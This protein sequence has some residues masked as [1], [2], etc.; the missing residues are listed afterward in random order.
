MDI[1][2]LNTKFEKAK[3]EEILAF[4]L[5][6]FRGRIALSS[7]LGAE[8]QVLTH[9]I[10]KI[11]PSARIFTLD[12]GRLFPETYD[13]IHKINSRYNINIEV[14]FPDWQLVEAMV[15]EKGINLFYYSIENRKECCHIRKMVPLQRAFMGLEAWICGLRRDQSHA[16]QNHQ[17]VEW[18]QQYNILKI[19]P[20]INWKEDDVWKYIR[21]NNVPY[22]KL[23]DK[24]YPSIGCQPCTIPVEPGADIRSGRWWWEQEDKKECGLHSD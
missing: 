11:D 14:I 5:N 23:H 1:G 2:V 18:D 15:L 9:M 10:V 13:L 17:V 16:R 4:F 6:E 3:P 24:G 22:N 20:L 7:S 19:N 21:E 8:D 12:T